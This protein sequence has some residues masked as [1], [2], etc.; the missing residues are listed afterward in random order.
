MKI[1]LQELRRYIRCNIREWATA[2]PTKPMSAGRNPLSPETSDREALGYLADQDI[3]TIDDDEYLPTHLREPFETP[4]DCYGPVPPD[5]E[6]PYAQ[7]DPFV[8][9]ASPVPS[10]PIRK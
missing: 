7:Q 3:D 9:D 6:E 8:R 1:M 10:S 4:E 5:A 2:P